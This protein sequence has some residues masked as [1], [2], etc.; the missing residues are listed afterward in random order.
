MLGLDHR[1]TWRADGVTL[2]LVPRPGLDLGS[3]AVV[4]LL[5][6]LAGGFL[7]IERQWVKLPTPGPRQEHVLS[8][9]WVSRP[10]EPG[11]HHVCTYETVDRMATLFPDP[12]QA[13]LERRWVVGFPAMLAAVGWVAGFA[14]LVARQQRRHAPVTVQV[15]PGRITLD[16]R[17]FPAGT[18]RSVVV[19]S[20]RIEVTDRRGWW[21]R[22]RRV[23]PLPARLVALLRTAETPDE[24][25]ALAEARAALDRLRST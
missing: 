16:G 20:D 7:T 24:P 13:L 18:V 6:V 25:E 21:R 2:E 5:L 15:G 8:E 17:S 14:W 12:N 11:G 22:S 1:E 3:A 23:E 19:R 4:G 9:E 10:T